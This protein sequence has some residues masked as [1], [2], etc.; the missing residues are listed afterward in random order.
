MNV[1]F[2]KYWDNNISTYNAGGVI[3]FDSENLKTKTETETENEN[4]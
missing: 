4:K 1:H 2:S 3:I